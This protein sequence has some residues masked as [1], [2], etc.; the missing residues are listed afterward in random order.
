MAEAG[1]RP[2]VSVVV[3]CR[4][5]EA[6]V[7][8]MAAAVTSELERLELP[9]ELIFI[10][11][12]SIDRTVALARALCARDR[13]IKLIVNQ[14]NFGQLRSPVHGLYQASGDVV[15][16]LCADFQDP[17]GLIPEFIR[18][19]REGYPIVLGVR[20]GEPGKPI[21]KVFRTIGY[22]LAARFFDYPM[23]PN[24]TGFG[25]YDQRVVKR[26][27]ALSEPEPL[28]RALLVEFG[29]P[30]KTVPY[31][32]APRAG[33]RSN[34][35]FFTLADFTLSAIS[36]SGKRLLRLPFLLGFM[37]LSGALVFA[38]LAVAAHGGVGFWPWVILAVLQA[39]VGLVLLV[40]GLMGD[41]VRLITERVRKTPLVV[42]AERVNFEP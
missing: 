36:G 10:D 16:G 7:E 24:A 31:P 25:L 17:P 30:I 11:N 35:N 3:A 34:N 8:A 1:A 28:W 27:A 19:W 37:S 9:F 33:G 15:I 2:F 18:H 12:A 29:D 4:N 22:F 13:R 39:N 38:G 23:I 42:E 20:A 26:L 40:L 5:E 41:Q 21:V 14:A 32:R 6:N